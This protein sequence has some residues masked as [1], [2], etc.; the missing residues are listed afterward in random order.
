MLM[1][2][3]PARARRL[4]HEWRAQRFESGQW[5]TARMVRWQFGRFNEAVLQAGLTPRRA[6]A[7]IRPNLCGAEAITDA[8]VAVDPPLWRRTVHG[9]LG[10]GAG[11]APPAGVADRPLQRRR[12]AEHTERGSPVRLLRAAVQAAGLVPRPRSSTHEQRAAARQQNRLAVASLRRTD[13]PYDVPPLADAV[14]AVV[15]GRRVGDPIAVHARSSTSRRR[16]LPTP[17]APPRALTPA[18]RGQLPPFGDGRARTRAPAGHD[19]LRH[20]EV[21]RHDELLSGAA[22]SAPGNGSRRPSNR[23]RHASPRGR[24]RRA[25]TAP[26]SRRRRDRSSSSGRSTAASCPDGHSESFNGSHALLK[27]S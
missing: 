11:P 25:R 19:L 26:R 10:P 21:A 6:P 1:D 12:L 23:G 20:P 8:I 27:S 14:P 17:I 13:S 4:G 5:P 3:E 22:P 16:R 7:R 9:R 2:W 24:P 18:L 15:A